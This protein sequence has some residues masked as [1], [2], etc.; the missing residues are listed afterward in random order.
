[1]T[2]SLRDDEGQAIPLYLVAGVAL[3][4]VALAFFTVGRA[5]D[6]RNRTQTAADAAAIAAAKAD[7]DELRPAFLDALDSGDLE[8]LE[9]LLKGLDFGPDHCADAQAYAAANNAT[10][11]SCNAV[12]G[13]PGYEVEVKSAKSMGKSVIDGTE[14]KHAQAKATAVIEPRCELADGQDDSGPYRFTCDQGEQV[15]DEDNPEWGLDLGD[16]FKIRLSD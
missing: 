5:E 11:V 13:P 8:A 2:S 16:F 15:L 12:D 6:S 14:N 3:L 1:M 9:E 4:F 10:Y 7:R